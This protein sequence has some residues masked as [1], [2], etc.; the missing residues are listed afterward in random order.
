[1]IEP[2]YLQRYSLFGG[3]TEDQLKNI[4]PLMEQEEYAPGDMII[5]EGLPNDKVH[6]IIKG[7]V[8]VTKRNTTLAKFSEG[9]A[10][11]EMEVLDV[12]PAVAAI[13]AVTQVTI[14]SISNKTL[15]AIYNIDIKAFSLI[16]M[17]LARDMSRRLR[18]TDEKLASQEPILL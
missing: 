18:K 6:F 15:R 14:V 4:I 5:T 9:D 3:L 10:F 8:S 1:M 11:G 16:V 12:M 17:N 7:Q 2:S 13:K